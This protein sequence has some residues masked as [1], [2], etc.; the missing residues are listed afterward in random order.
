MSRDGGT[1]R[2]QSFNGTDMDFILQGVVLV[3]EVTY[4]LTIGSASVSMRCRMSQN[5]VYPRGI[6]LGI[7]PS[8]LNLKNAY[9]APKTDAPYIETPTT[10]GAGSGGAQLTDGSI[11]TN[12]LAD[13]AVTTIKLADEAVTTEKIAYQAVTNTEL[14][15]DAVDIVNCSFLSISS[16]TNGQ[17]LTYD[18]TLNKWKNAAAAGGVGN[19]LTLGNL[20]GTDGSITINNGS[21]A[22][23]ILDN[24]SVT[25][26]GGWSS[27]KVVMLREIDCVKDGVAKKMLIFASA[28]Y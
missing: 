5:K 22:Y 21:Y 13:G 24:T 4:D 11:T 15:E 2:Y 26:T 7:P 3:D 16:P 6:R 14:S 12:L 19:D 1:I 18:S 8:K 28:P 23:A 20:S 9:K 25:P 27:T 17:V 10:P